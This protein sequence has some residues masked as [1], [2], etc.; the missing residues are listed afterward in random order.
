VT[1]NKHEA[2][3]GWVIGGAVL[4]LAAS[5]TMTRARQ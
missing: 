4:T 3:E 5:A 1:T 2:P